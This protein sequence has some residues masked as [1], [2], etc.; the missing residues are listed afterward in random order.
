MEVIFENK[1][2]YTKEIL[3][4]FSKEYYRVI[5]SK[6]RII[7]LV[8]GIIYICATNL[9]IRMHGLNLTSVILL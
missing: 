5:M 6:L 7:A 9:F 2:A 4:E 1:T 8:I 3:G